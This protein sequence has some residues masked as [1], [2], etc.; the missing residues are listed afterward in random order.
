MNTYKVSF[1]KQT[2]MSAIL[3][4]VGAEWWISGLSAHMFASAREACDWARRKKLRLRRAAN[5]DQAR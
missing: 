2:L 1:T 5:C 4:R 3:F